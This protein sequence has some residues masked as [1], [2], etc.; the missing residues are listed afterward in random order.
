[1]TKRNYFILAFFALAL[2]AV[3]LGSCS[4]EDEDVPTPPEP[5]VEE[6]AEVA[7]NAEHYY[8]V[9]KVYE[10]GKALDGV[11]VSSS[12][13]E[14]TTGSDGAYQLTVD[15]KGSY[16][17]TFAKTGYITVSASATI[18]ANASLFGSAVLEQTLT[19]KNDPVSVGVDGAI[20]EE[21]KKAVSLDIPAGAL[22]ETT[23][24][25]VTDF[26]PGATAIAGNSTNAV[27]MALDFEPSGLKFDKKALLKVVNPLGAN[28][29]FGEVSHVISSSATPGQSTGNATYNP[30]TNT[31]EYEIDGFSQHQF[32][33]PTAV[34]GATE[35]TE[36][37]GTIDVNNLG[38]NAVKTETIQL[39]VTLG[40]ELVGD[41]AS[42]ILAQYPSIG[43]DAATTL[44]AAFS[45]IVTGTLGTLAGT[46]TTTVSTPYNVS[47]DTRATLQILT[48]TTV[49][50]LSFPLVVNGTPSTFN[51]PVRNYLGSKLSEKFEFG[52]N[53]KQH[54]G[55]SG[56]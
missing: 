51:V 4:K 21:A 24:I 34:G 31:Y 33:I 54:S 47:G 3:S 22:G 40:W 17:V 35:G 14:A 49:F 48:V 30:E 23:E 39:P 9:G 53:Q 2:V 42:L 56:Q 44:A 52:P 19:A 10:A 32:Q 41:L 50:N 12:G 38:N 15:K 26:V 43:S 55:G 16:T 18:A 13:K 36:A 37:A 46:S 28:V 20:I 45:G 29:H 5:P 25:S 1:M 7:T 8:I 27:L 11:T 6:P